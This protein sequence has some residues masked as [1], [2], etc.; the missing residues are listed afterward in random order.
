MKRPLQS[1]KDIIAIL[2]ERPATILDAASVRLDEALGRVAAE[3]IFAPSELPPFDRSAVDGYGLHEDDLHPTA[4]IELALTARLAAGRDATGLAIARGQTIWLATGSTIPEGVA[5]VIMEEHVEGPSSD[6][7][8]LADRRVTAGGNIRRRGEDVSIGDVIV[9]AGTILDAR[10]IAI[11]AAVGCTNIQVRRKLRALVISVG[12][13]LLEATDRAAPHKTVDSNRPMLRALLSRSLVE[14]HD[15][16]IYADEPL[17]LSAILRNAASTF[18]L[19]VTSGAAAGSATDRVADAIVLAGGRI[20]QHHVAVKPGKPLLLG[21][22]GR[23]IFL[24]LPG[25]P[26]AAYVTG[27]IFAIPLI[28]SMAGGTAG[29]RQS[30]TAVAGA[31]IRHQSGRTEFAPAQIIEVAPDGRKSVVKLGAGGSASLSPLVR[32]DGLLELDARRG[33]IAS[34]QPVL[35]HA[36][37]AR[38]DL[39]QS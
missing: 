1:I 12:D 31:D 26:F 17:P 35:F 14:L 36:F 3:D 10:H 8:H 16:G 33:D 19:I 13:E 15:G 28:E 2:A 6:I 7:V 27:Q 22:I 21:E 5:A 9:T 18:D 11:L 23:S 38:C 4:P 37:N 20:T 32:A 34:G 39:G 24:G 30:E 25:N 29:P